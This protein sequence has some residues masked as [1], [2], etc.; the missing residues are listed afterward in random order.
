VDVAIAD[1]VLAHAVLPLAVLNQ[2]GEVPRNGEGTLTGGLA[3]YSLYATADGRQLAVAA[4]EHKFWAELCS[5][6]ERPDL[7][8]LHRTG[9]AA[10][11]A[12]V[13]SELTALFGSQPLAHWAAS[14]AD[15]PACV[16]PV[17]RLDETLA[18][19][20][21]RARGMVLPGALPQLGCAVQMSGF[22]PAPPRAA[23][24]PGE[25]SDAVLTEAGFDADGI[26]ALRAC[27]ALA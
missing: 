23:P 21:F 14:F 12:R 26:A 7:A 10:A 3:C 19:P 24:T 27:G 15:A 1:G 6:I 13:R 18:H 11:E 9:N 16:T 25:H 2:T 4:L 17:L 20:H 5:R 22:Q 8:V